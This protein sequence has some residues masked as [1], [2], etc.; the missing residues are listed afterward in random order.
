[1]KMIQNAILVAMN[2]CVTELKK[3]CPQLSGMHETME[4]SSASSSGSSS[5]SSSSFLTLENGL[6][7]SFDLMIRHQLDPDWHKISLRTKQ[8][9]NDMTTLR[10]LL[11]YLIR[12]DAFSFYYLLLK[13]QLASN[14]QQFPSMW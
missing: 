12:Y 7:Q 2:T 14:E 5:S 1:M 4:G 9:V 13:L 11:D 3:A 10:K 8:L 6:F